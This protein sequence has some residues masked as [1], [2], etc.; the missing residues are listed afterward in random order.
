MSG[1]LRVNLESQGRLIAS[2]ERLFI[3]ASTKDQIQVQSVSR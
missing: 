3:K 2:I 1:F